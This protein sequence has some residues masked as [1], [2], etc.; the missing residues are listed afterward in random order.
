VSAFSAQFVEEI[1]ARNPLGDGS[2]HPTSKPN[3][4][5]TVGDDEFS[6][7]VCGS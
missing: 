6:P 1:H 4:R 2:L 3:E 7:A 5:R